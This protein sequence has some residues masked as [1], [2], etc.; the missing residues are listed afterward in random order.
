MGSFFEDINFA[1]DGGLYAEL[2][3]N[4]S[5]EFYN[6]LITVFLAGNSTVVDQDKEPYAAWGQMI[7]AFFEP[8]KISIA[9]YAESGESLKKLY[10]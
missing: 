5:F 6:Q 10:L 8:G 9:N 3:K 2:I 4:R 1:E 7:P